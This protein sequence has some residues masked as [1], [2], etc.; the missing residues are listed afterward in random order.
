[1]STTSSERQP[2]KPPYLSSRLR[3]FRY[4]I[5]GLVE[6]MK[7]EAHMKIHV[8]AAMLTLAAGYLFSI[9]AV[10]WMLVSI[11]MALVMMAELFNTAIEKICD[12]VEPNQH[13]AVKY[14]KDIS[15]AAVL[16]VC[17]AAA[18]CGLV[19]FYPHARHTWGF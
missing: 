2:E 6:S 12:L 9:T 1:M 17:L 13:P 14:I 10:E 19:I 15:S 11:C 5:S 7:R 16:L 18:I 4:A 8:A 3:A